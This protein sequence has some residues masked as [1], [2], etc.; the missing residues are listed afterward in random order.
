MCAPVFTH[1]YMTKIR[2]KCYISADFHLEI[3]AKILNSNY[4]KQSTDETE[5]F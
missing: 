5:A 3:K 1:A 4:K 2:V